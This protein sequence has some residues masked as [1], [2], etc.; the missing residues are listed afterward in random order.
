MFT[1]KKIR[2]SDKIENFWGRLRYKPRHTSFCTR[3]ARRIS[4][5]P[6]NIEYLHYV[7]NQVDECFSCIE[8][9]EFKFENFDLKIPTKIYNRK[10]QTDPMLWILN[11]CQKFN[12][13]TSYF[14]ERCMQICERTDQK[15]KYHI[16]NSNTTLK[17]QSEGLF[18]W[19]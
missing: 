5:F 2:A 19:F 8:N 17:T 15:L 6:E 7:K 4:F 12:V 16:K 13:W 3:R 14:T 10:L 18:A 11:S 9:S 1:V